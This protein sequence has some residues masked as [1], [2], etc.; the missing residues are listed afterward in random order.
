MSELPP[1]QLAYLTR[2]G[3]VLFLVFIGAYLLKQSLRDLQWRIR[4]GRKPVEGFFLMAE[5]RGEDAGRLQSFPLYHTT[6][7]GSARS[8]DLCFRSKQVA[9]RHAL[10]YIFD[11]RWYLAPATA[12]ANLTLNGVLIQQ[13]I[14][15]E[16]RDRIGLGDLELVF[17]NER[18]AALSEGL[19]Y[20]QVGRERRLDLGQVPT[21]WPYLLCNLYCLLAIGLMTLLEY[22][23][24]QIFLEKSLLL[25]GGQLVLFN[26]FYLALPL[27]IRG[28]DR[29]ILLAFF[30]IAFVG[31][32]LQMS[33]LSLAWAG[34]E[35][36][37]ERIQRIEGRL[38]MLFYLMLAGIVLFVLS[39]LIGAKSNLLERLP[40]V[41]AIA[42]PA[43]LILTRV[44]GRG[45]E[46]H[47]ASLW[48]RIGPL[49]LQLTE[50]VKIAYLIV[51]A[52]FFKARPPLKKQLLFAI[53]AALVFALILLLP[54]LGS[55][56]VLL[57]TTLV[58]FFV[59][60]SEYAVTG[61]ILVSG[62]LISVLIYRAFPYVQRRILGWTTLWT[63]VNDRNSQIVLG[64]QSISRG[65][66]FGRGLG[67]GSPSGT[68]LYA[69]DMV[70]A[71]LS[72]EM[73][74][75]TGV[76]LIVLFM[77]I[78]LR[79]T[80]W[81]MQVQDGFSSSLLLGLCTALFV[82]AAVVISGTTG[83]IPLTGATLPFVA[84]GGSSLLAKYIVMGLI[85]GLTARREGRK[86]FHEKLSSQP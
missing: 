48:L 73:G 70:F 34:D 39:A 4:L 13:A 6:A 58:V 26:L 16:D 42:V 65:G 23:T 51:L 63:E 80:R 19:D 15:L 74:L 43:M 3:F 82:E 76:M 50:Y 25:L 32:L 35:L 54:D 44:L 2:Y 37:P 7:I 56:M 45:A 61:G 8:S 14:P 53:W 5:G 29:A 30:Q 77:V 55:I 27:L 18:Q 22:G 57:P 46:T 47:G 24:R 64:L 31:N 59:M 68:P 84:K 21:A 49:S 17:V 79:G 62:S 83:L 85:V 12:K 20:R 11:G 28:A 66:F 33:F 40:L 81:C 69:D 60:T 36:T 9:Y 72:E 10:L 75:L 38:N 52:S 78:W 86:Q 1:Q 41:A 71:S 67:N